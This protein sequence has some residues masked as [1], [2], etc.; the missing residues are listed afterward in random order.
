MTHLEPPL[1]YKSD[2]LPLSKEE[3][4]VEAEEL[5]LELER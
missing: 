4:E 5:A 2:P 1:R 3:G